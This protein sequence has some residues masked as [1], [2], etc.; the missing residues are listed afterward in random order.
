[1][2]HKQPSYRSYYWK[3]S[4][5]GGTLEAIEHKATTNAP[6]CCKKAKA[7]LFTRISRESRKT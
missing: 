7:E 6:L 3:P 5:T 2:Y 4:M 1:M